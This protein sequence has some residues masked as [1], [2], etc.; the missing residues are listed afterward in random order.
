MSEESDAVIVVVSEET[1]YISIVNKGKI[2]RGITSSQLRDSL[3][4]YLIE[5]D[6]DKK[7]NIFDKLRAK[8][9]KN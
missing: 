5:K 4:N 1:G 6:Q 3:Q 9:K 2:Q 7:S 8:L